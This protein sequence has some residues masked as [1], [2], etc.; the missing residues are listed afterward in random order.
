M[1]CND[2][3]DKIISYI[4]DELTEI[5]RQKF[6]GELKINSDL[7]KEYYEIKKLLQSLSDLPE[8]TASSD[9]IDSLNKKIDAY[10]N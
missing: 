7:K 3:K 6:E 1:D 2:Y 4:E 10:E 5:D 9:F 8:I